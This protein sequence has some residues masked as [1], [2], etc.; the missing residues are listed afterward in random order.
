[1]WNSGYASSIWL[2]SRS[3]HRNSKMASNSGTECILSYLELWAGRDSKRFW[4]WK[5]YQK[6]QR[7]WSGGL[8]LCPNLQS[9]SMLTKVTVDGIRRIAIGHRRTSTARDTLRRLDHEIL[10]KVFGRIYLVAT[11]AGNPVIPSS[12]FHF[13]FH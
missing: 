5:W 10:E 8:I 6:S 2:L 7:L 12:V 3:S 11:G 13:G 9:G 4:C 1:M